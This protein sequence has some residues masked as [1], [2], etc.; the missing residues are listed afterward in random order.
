M[1]SFRAEAVDRVVPSFQ[2]H[3]NVHGNS[4]SYTA[5]SSMGPPPAAGSTSS[6][7]SSSSLSSSLLPGSSGAP[8]LTVRIGSGGNPSGYAQTLRAG[9][10]LLLPPATRK[11]QRDESSLSP[12]RAPTFHVDLPPSFSNHRVGVA[13]RCDAMATGDSSSLRFTLPASTSK[14][15]RADEPSSPTSVSEPKCG[16]PHYSV[17]SVS[18][19]SVALSSVTTTTP[20]VLTTSTNRSRP[21]T[22]TSTPPPVPASSDKIRSVVRGLEHIARCGPSG[23]CSN[24]LCISTRGFVQKVSSHLV[25]MVGKP[26][27]VP[28]KCGA[29]QLWLGIV[30]SH[31]SICMEVS[32]SIPMCASINAHSSD[33]FSDSCRLATRRDDEEDRHQISSR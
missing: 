15:L 11:R 17:S 24:P 13:A 8:S 33:P 27:H 25:A 18:S 19:S 3:A 26:G 4:M 16:R 12:R 9:P 32:C 2:P 7:S 23:G 30:K 22:P 20:S 5:S 1:S 6:S 29:C 28:A 31:A 14:R 10:P 21:P